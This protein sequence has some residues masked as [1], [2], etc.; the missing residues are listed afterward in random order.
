MKTVSPASYRKALTALLSL[1]ALGYL[2]YHTLAGGTLLSSNVYDTYALQAQNWLMGRVDVL[3]GASYSW[4]EL[5]IFQGRYYVSF[6]PVPTL[7]SL[8]FVALLGMS[9]ANL[10]MVVYT[11][12]SCAAV[13]QCIR[14]LGGSP[15]TCA[16][17][18]LF[19]TFATNLTEVSRTGGVWNQ[20][21]ALNLALCFSALWCLLSHRHNLCLILLALAVGCRPFS[22]VYLL[23]VGIYLLW[24][25]KEKLRSTL[26]SL[27]PGISGV[28]FIAAAMMAY[29]AARFGNPLEFGH[30]YLPEF[31]QSEYGQFHFSYLLPN[32]LQLFRLPTL[33][34]QLAVEFPLFNGF[35]FFLVN[36]VFVVWGIHLFQSRRQPGFSKALCFSL[37]PL[38]VVLLSICAHKTMGGWQ[39]GA[40]YTL[41]L[42]PAALAGVGFFQ[43]SQRSP[44][45]W[46]GYLCAIGVIINVFGMAFMLMQELG[47]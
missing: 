37:L 46:E 39:F 19:F 20:A 32:L 4:L 17:W 7:C 35:L 27:L 22:A 21:Q 26:L 31:T 14:H 24:Q 36:P 25:S 42:L 3:D 34:Q 33:N 11:L 40:R 2:L 44:R 30:N 16:F 10:L 9:P 12:I 15:Y 45:F 23:A 5:A 43:I 18:A 8:P 6:P 1:A 41:D 47:L 29:N 13:F 38:L 28:F